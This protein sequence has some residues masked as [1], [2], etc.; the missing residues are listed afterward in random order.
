[1][2]FFPADT[3]FLRNLSALVLVALLANIIIGGENIFNTGMA[4]GSLGLDISFEY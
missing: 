2:M 4:G 1:M 3:L